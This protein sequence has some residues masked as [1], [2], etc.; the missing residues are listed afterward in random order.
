[1]PSGD[2]KKTIKRTREST[3]IFTST[4]SP[5]GRTRVILYS[6]LISNRLV[7]ISKSISRHSSPAG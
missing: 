4:L 2:F 6:E 1:M 7:G 3:G 5:L